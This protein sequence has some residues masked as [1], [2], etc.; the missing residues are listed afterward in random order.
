MSYGR[1]PYGDGGF[2]GNDIA[3]IPAADIKPAL[4]V[5]VAFTTDALETPVWV[6]ITTDVRSWDVK[7]GRNRELERFQPGRATVVLGNLSRQYDSQHATGPWFGNLKPMRRV[8]IRETFN[9]VTY[10]TFDGFVDRW[11]LDYPKTGK[12]ATATVVATDGFKILAR[13]DLPRS[14]YTDVIEGDTPR[15]WWRLD[16]NLARLEDGVVLNSST[17]GSTLNGTFLESPKVGGQGIVVNDPGTSMTTTVDTSVPPQGAFIANATF[18]LLSETDFAVE[19]W[20]RP[21]LASG[22]G[23]VWSVSRAADAQ[24]HAVCA[25][26]TNAGIGLTDAYIFIVFDS[27]FT[28]LYGV[29]TPNNTVV[30][31]SI[32]HIV[33]DVDATGQMAIIV[34]GTR[35][36]TTHPQATS[37][38]LS[39]ITR[40][41]N[42][43]L[44][45]AHR[46]T[47]D[48]AAD[49]GV[50]WEGEISE[51]AVYLSA[52]G[53]TTAAAHNTAGRTP[54]KDDL[55]GARLARVLDLADWPS[56]LRE[57]DTGATT[58]QSAATGSWPVLEHSQKVAES[59]YGLLFMDRVGKVRF[60][61]RSAVFTRVPVADAIFGDSGSE[62]GYR[63]IVFADG[64]EVIRNRAAI[65]RLNGVAKTSV[66]PASVT[67]YGRFDYK[68]DGLLHS[69]DSY[70]QDYADF[71]VEE[72][73]QPRRR[74]VSLVMG[75][76]S[77]AGASTMVP[78]MLGRELG[79]AVTVRHTPPGGGARYTLISV[80]EGI[81]HV[82]APGGARQTKFVL[83]PEL[84]AG[85][86]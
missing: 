51:F 57:I 71:I 54:W 58:L 10:P 12:D 59:E 64:D 53:A 15:L 78:Q 80:I 50:N 7:R 21:A 42:G 1:Y 23:I 29:V 52:L 28:L 40:P 63:G 19:C 8:R 68:L 2:G 27:A 25:Q 76:A 35:Y 47:T 82:G 72:Y 86:F 85:A 30:P 33:C 16:E 9:G 11:L 32:N 48:L 17:Q 14:V 45:V 75:P 38:S 3:D 31:P 36:T 56:A 81:E 77:A 49:S 62:V 5:E 84:V 41:T 55:P 22:S 44:R 43:E 83:S 34:D 69:S 4:A 46:R 73:E 37:S 65:S 74:V 70:S 79:D 26:S 20:V 24:L 39:G 60:M 67:E 18:S 6:D 61:S 13:T 66:A